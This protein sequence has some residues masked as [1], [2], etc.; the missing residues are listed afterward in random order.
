MPWAAGFSSFGCAVEDIS[1]RYQK[2]TPVMIPLGADAGYKMLMGQLL[3]N[4]GWEELEKQ[5]Q[6]DFTAEGLPWSQAKVQQIA[7]VRYGGQMEDLEIVSP[8]SRINTPEDI[9]K[10]IAAFEDL[11]EKVYA[12]VAKH[13]RGGY[14]IMELGIQATVPKIKPKLTKWKL[15]G[16]KPASD[17]IKEVR[18]VYYDGKWGKATIY[19]MDK[20]RPGNEVDGLAVIEAPATTLFLPPGKRIRMDEWTLMWLT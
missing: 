8:V 3:I 17:A 10:L 2:S 12:G 14:Q 6:A 19:N 4:P 20:L 18:E 9:D 13:K 15:E 1:H 11:Y 5:A 16:K 7:Y